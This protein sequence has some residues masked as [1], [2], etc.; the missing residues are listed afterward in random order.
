VWKKPGPYCQLERP[1]NLNDGTTALTVAR[2]PLLPDGFD[3]WIQD[4]CI[5]FQSPKDGEILYLTDAPAMP[6]I[7]VS[8]MVGGVFPDPTYSTRFFWRAQVTFD[9]K[10]CP[11]GVRTHK[12]QTTGKVS[13]K[14]FK[15]STQE[16]FGT[17]I[18]G[19]FE[20]VFDEIRGGNLTLEVSA[21]VGGGVPL[22]A[23]TLGVRIL[24]AN[25]SAAQI[26]NQ[27]V[28]ALPNDSDAYRRIVC[29][30]SSFHQFIPETGYP[31][32]SGDNLLGVGLSQHTTK[33]ALSPTAE[34]AWNW[35]ENLKVGIGIFNDK[36]KIAKHYPTSV[37]QSNAFK[38]LVE[39]YNDKMKAQGFS[40]PIEVKVPE[41]KKDELRDDAIRAYNGFGTGDDG[42]GHSIHEFRIARQA[43]GDLTVMGDP[44]TGSVSAV[45]EPVPLA[46]RNQSEDTKKYV[47]TVLKKS[48]WC[49]SDAKAQP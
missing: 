25:P 47:Q 35:S 34:E 7:H 48:P 23:R 33:W 11:H 30:E 21:S 5:Y 19:Q 16:K 8:A 3:A 46:D 31:Q 44:K 42:F 37:R 39:K 49:G 1:L 10:D 13:T 40:V 6:K 14:T 41:Y 38:K 12:D 17:C 36:L 28:Q 43:N 18:G 4:P 29:L 24:G 22:L 20:L 26:V 45:W 2:T 15:T 27:I 9:S 32:F